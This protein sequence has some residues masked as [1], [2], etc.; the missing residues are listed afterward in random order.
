MERNA[1]NTVAAAAL[2]LI[3]TSCG[4]AGSGE[5]STA[6]PT[7]E[8]EPTSGIVTTQPN[9]ATTTASTPTAIEM[10]LLEQ[11]TL[12][13]FR[14]WTGAL[15]AADYERAWRL[16]APTSQAA[17]GSYEFFVGLGSEMTEGWGS[18]AATPN[19]TI[20]IREDLAGRLEAV[21]GG[22]V[23]R[24]GMTEDTTTSVFVVASGDRA[25]ISP[26]EE[27][28]NVAA[29][30]ANPDTT[31]PLPEAA[32]FGR[33]IVYANAA[34]RVWIVEEDGTVVDT[35]L[36]SGREGVPAPG[37]YEVYSKSETAFA[38]HDDIT[39]RF[40]VRFAR[41]SSGTAIGFHSIPNNANGDP[42]QTEEQLGEFH[43]AGCV[44]QSI[45]HAA[46]LF[47]WA[48]IGTPVHVLP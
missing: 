36:V 21:I 23:E 47:E 17:L 13:A 4:A 30:L 22:T 6:D 11:Q 15:A 5:A 48:S 46:A 33:R 12:D 45:G 24:E 41:A 16:M 27:F 3:L 40:M 29:G 10:A 8:P 26:F 19:L 20:S 43:S 14:E 2:A 37:I 39:M 18:W 38:G 34:Q 28:G 35:Y 44:R 31:V 9:V 25:A 1:A 7:V 32:G 42:M